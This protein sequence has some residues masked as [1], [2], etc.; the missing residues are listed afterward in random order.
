MTADHEYA[1]SHGF[2][3]AA[4]LVRGAYMDE[5]RRLGEICWLKRFLKCLIHYSG[6]ARGAIGANAPPFK[7]I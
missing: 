3:I 7:M 5:E 1:Q 2:K 6:L 4:K